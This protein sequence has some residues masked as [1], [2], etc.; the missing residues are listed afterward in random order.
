MPITEI[1]T[2]KHSIPFTDDT[3]VMNLFCSNISPLQHA[4]G[5]QVTFELYGTMELF[6]K[7]AVFVLCT[8]LPFEAKISFKEILKAICSVVVHNLRPDIP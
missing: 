4:C 2:N 3:V 6:V 1:A 8:I 7:V 5:C